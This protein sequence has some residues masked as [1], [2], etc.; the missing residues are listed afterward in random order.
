VVG[1]I[2]GWDILGHPT[3]TIQCF[4]WRVFFK[5]IAPWHNTTFLS[6]LQDAGYFGVAASKVPTILER[7]IALELRAKRIYTTLARAFGDY[8]QVGAF[9]DG[10]A[11][12]EQ[13]HADLLEVC[14]AVAV[15]HRWKAHLFNPWE[16][17]LPRLEQQMDA[18]EAAVPG[19]DSVDAA[20]QLVIQIESAE[21]NQVFHAALAATD[22]AFVKNLR[23]FRGAMEAHVTHIVERLPELS[24]K[25]VLACRELRAKFPRVLS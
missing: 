5:A 19:I 8:E 15:R 4:G 3:S 18:A 24:P 12:Q 21:I 7:C 22:S 16:D 11:L 1:V 14:R 2:T 6:L 17:Y 20:L 25:L 13:Y 10:L 23:P 9:F